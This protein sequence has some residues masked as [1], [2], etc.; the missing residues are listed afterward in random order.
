M[1]DS[2]YRWAGQA[3]VVALA[4]L[5]FSAPSA[6]QTPALIFSFVGSVFNCSDSSQNQAIN[7]N[8]STSGTASGLDTLITVAVGS[9]SFDVPVATESIDAI[10][11]GVSEIGGS[12]DVPF[13]PYPLGPVGCDVQGTLT[14]SV[15]S[16]SGTQ[17][18][19][20][21]PG[22]LAT[23]NAAITSFVQTTLPA[24]SNRI[25]AVFRGTANG[26]FS[27]NNV[28]SINGMAAGDGERP[29]IGA[30]AGYSFTD[31]R[32]TFS[33]T[34][35]E[36]DRHTILLGLDTMPSDSILLGVSVSLERAETETQFNGGEQD[37][38]AISL[39][40]Y[41]GF[42]LTDWLTVDMAV[43][44]GSVSAKQFRTSGTSR[45]TSDVKSTRI[46]GSV[47]ATATWAFDR[48][49]ATGHTG[50]L[51]VT[52]DD[53]DFRESNGTAIGDARSKLGRFLFGGELAYSAGAWEPYVGGTFE[54]DFASSKQSF[55]TGV[56]APR[57]D[58][59]DLLLSVGLRYFG[60]N[61]ISASAAYRTVVGRRNLDEDSFNLNARWQF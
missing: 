31:S 36:S 44:V 49:L 26:L 18:S 53:E 39:T 43:G 33:S 56:A 4:M 20:N 28:Y 55:S 40:P 10:I 37:V 9:E 13:G 51:Y 12:L 21:S 41:A 57:R 50:L 45:V 2:F 38:T 22:N 27:G 32:N 19:S 23:T 47:N 6:A 35:F 16:S 7:V 24:I 54:Y 30:W 3:V 15:E 11:E 60:D 8:F 29:P 59:S 17:I 14:L 1:T 25:S 34:A 5:F 58:D 42:L 48:I 52:Q 46:Y 61:N